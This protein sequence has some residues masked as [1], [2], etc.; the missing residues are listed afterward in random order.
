MPRRAVGAS[1]FDIIAQGETGASELWRI[2]HKD[3]A[4]FRAAQSL[5]IQ[6]SVESFDDFT[7]DQWAMALEAIRPGNVSYSGYSAVWCLDH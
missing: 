4:K 5:Y 1:R 7:D 3:S 6:T 2:I